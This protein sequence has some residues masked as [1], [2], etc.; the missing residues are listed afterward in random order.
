MRTVFCFFFLFLIGI[1]ANSQIDVQ[2]FDLNV[3]AGFGLHQIDGDNYSG[4][5]KPGYLVELNSSLQLDERVT[6]ELGLRS[7]MK[8]GK[9]SLF[10]RD[11]IEY[12]VFQTTYAGPRIGILVTDKDRARIGIGFQYNRLL[13]SKIEL[14]GKDNAFNYPG[15]SNNEF[16]YSI[17]GGIRLNNFLWSFFEFERT[18]GNIGRWPGSRLKGNAIVNKGISVGLAATVPALK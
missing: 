2:A 17:T 13:N 10:H 12:E 7:I 9:S 8:G 4:Y 15:F 16:T 14:E 3:K 6:L 11:F 5:Y 18:I 1:T